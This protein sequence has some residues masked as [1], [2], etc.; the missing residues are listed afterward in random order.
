MLGSSRNS[1]YA[2]TGV[3]KGIV[4]HCYRCR[5]SRWDIIK[6]VPSDV[7]VSLV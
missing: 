5:E 2:V 7:K 1:S 4:V 6:A 3:E